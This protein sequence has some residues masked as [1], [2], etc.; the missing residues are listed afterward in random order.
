[1]GSLLLR[2]CRGLRWGQD[3]YGEGAAL[4]RESNWLA[5]VPASK[6]LGR[7]MDFNVSSGLPPSLL[8]VGPPSRTHV[9]SVPSR[10]RTVEDG[11]NRPSFSTAGNDA[12]DGMDEKV[13]VCVVA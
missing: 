11:T 8:P 3:G 9:I 7:K 1:M 6:L 2:P 5:L 4:E 13:C 12:W 10:D